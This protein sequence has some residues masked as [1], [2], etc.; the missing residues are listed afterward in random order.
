MITHFFKSAYRSFVRNKYTSL[1]NVFGI[2]IG[3]A[4]ILLIGNW[5][6]YEFSF[7][8][9]HEKKERIFRLIEKQTFDGQ[10][11][12]YLSSMP[13]WLVETF[14]KDIHGI[15]AS[16]ALLNVGNLWFG[17][18]DNKIE[19]K[20]VTFT[21]NKLFQIFT[22]SFIEGSPDQALKNPYSI[23][24]T[25]SLAKTLFKESSVVGKKITYQN[26]D[27][28][29][30]TGVIRDIPD[31]SHFQAEMLV[32]IE[33]RKSAWNMESYNHTTSIYLL[34]NEDTKP[35]Q[36]LDPLQQSK[37][38]YMPH[39]AEYIEF[40]I[41]PLADI[42]L[43]ST[44]TMW[45]QN[46]KKSNIEIVNAFLL[47]GILVFII[48]TINYI[49]LSTATV[50]TR[51]KE[52]G[53]KKVI[54]SSKSGLIFQILI[55]SFILIFIS[56]WLSLL[57]VEL[58]KPLLTRFGLFEIGINIYEY[59]L[60]FP[61]SL[62]VIFL[63]A[64]LAGIYPAL[65]I[66][67]VQPIQLFK[68][69]LNYGKGSIPIRRILIISQLGITCILTIGVLFISKQ[70]L[71]MQEKDMGFSKDAIVYF[72]TG[73][74]Y[75]E[76]YETIKDELVK[77]DFI[78]D[79]TS[80]NIPLGTSMWRNCIH[81]EGENDEDQWITPYMMTDYNFF[82]F[83]QIQLKEGRSFSKEFALD[84]SKRA[85]LV[86]ESLANDIGMN[87]IIGKKFR[88]CEAPWGEVVGIIKDFNYR[89]LHHSI[90]PLAVQ[91]GVDDK[92]VVSVKLQT[93][94][95]DEALKLLEET[96]KMYQ[97]EQPFSYRFLDENLETM[98]ST[99]KRTIKIVST[100]SILSILI[101]CIGL[102]G[103]I[104]FIAASKTKEIGIR[105]VN[106][107]SDKNLII[108][109]SGDLIVNAIVAIFIAIPIGWFAIIRWRD[110]FAYKTE[111]SWW[112][113]LF[114]GLILLLLVS[115][116]ISYHTLKA[117][118]KNPVEVLRYE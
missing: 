53:L 66:S 74:S 34:L 105:K 43:Y 91:L 55:E 50:L 93:A 65:I 49:N 35:D 88:T 2:T 27:E 45:G 83:Y 22:L 29:T 92:N 82:E 64:L 116:A 111:I 54:G 32:S 76:N 117:A 67:R 11:E 75:R 13:E 62:F 110:S 3:L 58:V 48:S 15:E 47:I 99:E 90:E 18:G 24:V 108:L 33:T 44:H 26:K 63:I 86:N 41:Q 104:Q 84:K 113:F 17:E 14:E 112:I 70:I 12:K 81:F 39:N 37:N 61:V 114:S 21:N 9:F 52:A 5:V 1:I 16:A 101:S 57:L 56:F 23:V 20:N 89:S 94:K 85:F 71:Y 4:S 115:L 6:I 78:E 107:A 95:M 30:V 25:E 103:L 73:N 87:D 118:R 97:P 68:R 109:L 59:K 60:F 19:I 36:I 106:G 40:Q 38:R 80:S 72:Y 102:L 98:Y 31:N 100:F 28:Y 96:W 77:Y 42:H 69:N 10:G 7:D 51:F 79:I 46:W 8:G